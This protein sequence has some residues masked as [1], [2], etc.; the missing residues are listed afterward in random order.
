MI[1]V[2]VAR[3]VAVGGLALIVGVGGAELWMLYALAFV[4]GVGETLFDTAAQ[5]VMPNIVNSDQLDHANGRLYAVELTANQFLGPPI[6]AVIAGATLA[7]A[8]AVSSGLYLLAGLAL[9]AITGSFRASAEPRTTTIRRDIADGLRYLAG[10]RLLRVLAVCVGISN[11]ASSATMA[12]LP[13]HVISPGPMGLNE[14]GYGLFITTFAVGSVIGTLLVGRLRELLGTRWLLIVA[15][16]SF[17]LFSFAPVATDSPWLAGLGLFVA[18]AASVGWNIVTVSLRQRIVPD[19][20]LG[21]VNAGYRLV[22]WGTMP[23]GAALGGII[24]GTFTI[25]TALITASAIGAICTPIVYYGIPPQLLD[26]ASPT[27]HR[28]S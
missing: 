28:P 16:A 8:V 26:A 2:N 20:L 1:S 5:S 10:H 14:A 9:I 21:R 18:G 6:A 27:S 4:L 17:P 7:G 3:A 19:Q 11:L 12:L 15:T 13:L 25:P 23:L 22:A 24:A